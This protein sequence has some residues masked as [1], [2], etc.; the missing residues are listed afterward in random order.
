KDSIDRPFMAMFSGFG[1]EMARPATE[2]E[3][4][5]GMA[6]RCGGCAAKIGPGPLSRALSQLPPAPKPQDDVLVGLDRPDDAAVI[7]VAPGLAEVETVDQIRAF[8]SDPYLF[9][10]IAAL[11]ALSDVIAMGA[12]PTRA[13]ALAIAPHAAPGKVEADLV[14][15]L[16][17]ARR[18]LDAH[19]VALVGGHSSEGD[20][21]ALGFSVTGHI[22]P[23]AIRLKT[24]ARTGDR[25][26]LTKAIGTG[27]V[28][29][30]DMRGAA[31]GETGQAAIASMLQ[32]NFCA[33]RILAPFARAMTDVTGFGLAGHLL[34]M[35]RGTGLSAQLNLSAVPLLEGAL[36]LAKAGFRSSLTGQNEVLAGALRSTR[37]LEAHELALLFDP[38]TS[39]GLLAALPPDA[40]AGCVEALRGEGHAAALIGEIVSADGAEVE[41]RCEG[42]FG[43]G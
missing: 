14:Q 9:G 5:A 33:G 13:Q 1:R 32:S 36:A 28:L 15:L 22:D 42:S 16:A 34:E 21:L 26:V 11:H 17:G 41:I 12:I 6:M 38:Q 43:P 19:Q 3:L 25:L 24:G 40:A 18:A 20:S 10:Q 27:V 29:A 31:T 23:G 2:A 7:A 35:L 37:A 8:V 30:A 39:G 4:A